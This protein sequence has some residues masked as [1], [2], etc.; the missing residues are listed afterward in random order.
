M[1]LAYGSAIVLAGSNGWGSSPRPGS[2][3]TKFESLRAVA[4]ASQLQRL[5]GFAMAWCGWG[6]TFA[7]EWAVSFSCDQLRKTA[8]PAGIVESPRW[9]TSLWTIVSCY[10]ACAVI[11]KCTCSSGALSYLSCLF[12]G[13]IDYFFFDCYSPKILNPFEW[14]VFG[15]N[16]DYLSWHLTTFFWMD[17][18]APFSI[19]NSSIPSSRFPLGT[20]SFFMKRAVVVGYDCSLIICHMMFGHGN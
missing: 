12:T 15:K 16:F 9:R 4:A 19:R 3:Q 13:K 18:L 10:G 2:W 6:W 7:G 14:Q 17:E 20:F 8:R 5:N 11:A 1:I